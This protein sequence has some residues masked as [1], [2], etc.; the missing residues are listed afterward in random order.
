MIG[1]SITFKI[2]KNRLKLVLIKILSLFKQMIAYKYNDNFFNG[3][4]FIYFKQNM[5]SLVAS[6]YSINVIL[7][8]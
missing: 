1:R 3:V 7:A 6:F 2:L 8:F 5:A 4:L